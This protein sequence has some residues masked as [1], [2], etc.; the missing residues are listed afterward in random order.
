MHVST[1]HSN[2]RTFVKIQPYRSRTFCF[3]LFIEFGNLSG[4]VV[5][6]LFGD[7]HNCDDVRASC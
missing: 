5:H 7:L 6:L 4:E 3:E 1:S 2:K